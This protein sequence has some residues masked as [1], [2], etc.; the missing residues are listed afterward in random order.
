ML[1]SFNWLKEFVEIDLPAE[2]VADLLTMSGIEVE[3]VTPAGQGLDKVLTARIEEVTPHPK[4]EK[5]S[6]TRISLRDREV[7]VVC[8]APNVQVGQIVPYCPPGCVLPS[9]MEIKETKIKGVASPGMIC[10]EKELGLGED[11]SGILVFEEGTK[12]GVPLTDAYPLVED[13]ILE[14]SVTPNRGD[15]LSILGIARE[16]AAL[17]GRPWKVPTFAIQESEIGVHE[18]TSIEVPDAD[19]CLRYVA[20]VVEGVSVGPSPLE[21]RLRLTRSGVRPISNVV[22]ATNLVLLEC[23]Q[24][25]HAFDYTI[26]DGGRIVV[27]RCDPGET[28]VTLDGTERRLPPNSLMIR[29]ATRSVGLAGIMGGLNSEIRDDT[30]IVLIESACFERFG[31]RR[32][33]KALGMSTEASFRFERGVDP[34]GTLWAAHRVTYLIWKLAGGNVLA[35]HIDVYPNP[36]QRPAVPMKTKTA[37]ILLGVDVTRQQCAGYLERLGVKVNPSEGDEDSLMCTPPSWRWDLDRDVDMI[38]EV[39]RI[40]G[41]QNIPVSMPTYVS[42]PD[43]TREDHNQVRNVAGLMNA[44]GFTEIVTMSFGSVESAEE[45]LPDGKGT[46]ELALLNPL[47]EDYAVMRTSLMPGLLSTL[48]RNLNHRSEDL[49]LYEIGK[50]FHPVPDRE[51]PR[52]DLVLAAAATGARHP[53]SWHFHRGEIDVYGK[54]DKEPEVDFYDMKGALEN[55][56]EGL[57]I[58]EAAFAPSQVP[59]LHPGKSADVFVADRNVGFVGELSPRKIREHQFTGTVQIFQILLEP[60]LIQTRKERV[61]RPIPRYPFIERDLSLVVERNCSGDKIKRLISRLG[62]DIIG[63]V[64]LFDLYRG[65]S[66]PE[67]YQ[68]VAFRIR[69]QSEDRTLTDE[70]VQEVHSRVVEAVTTQLGAAL[71]E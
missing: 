15:C 68:S 38:E 42:A 33:A 45:F 20:R 19:L 58:S 6:L 70:E 21:V 22:D 35:G 18:R 43:N 51:L 17:L 26:L 31:I 3:G 14:T 62:H 39:A 67:G 10:S 12:V 59:F 60:L 52:E 41:F 56:L 57:G 32:T 71:R 34:E 63:S 9:G 61:F 13:Y 47:S 27:R 55:V 46:G 65:E 4:S 11:A 7:T 5:L 49:K 36:V 25:L 54:V 66:I 24:P 16:V 69:Y 2:E 8:G 44:S 40:H 30:S 29:D 64:V 28:F 53:R 23:G 1:V 48:K 50:T 37:K